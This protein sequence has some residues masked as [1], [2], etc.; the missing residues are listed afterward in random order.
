MF[1][2]VNELLR[3]GASLVAEGNFSDGAPFARLPTARIVQVYVSANTDALLE[4]YRA[5]KRHPAH[6]DVDYE[7]EIA[8]RIFRDEWRPLP[9]GGRLLE[10]DTTSFPSHDEVARRVAAL[11]D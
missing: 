10:V 3:A 1:S 5:R 2:V 6:P 8:A 4:R 11:A 7:D 9:I